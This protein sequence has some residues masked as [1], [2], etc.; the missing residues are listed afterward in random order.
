ME[1]TFTL[2][3]V[4]II[5]GPMA[6]GSVCALAGALVYERFIAG[7]TVKAKPANP[8]MADPKYREIMA[9][10]DVAKVKHAPRKHL[11]AK[12][13]RRVEELLGGKGVS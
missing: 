12:R 11:Y 13:D 1:L 8:L 7:K 4:D 3:P 2:T 5:F 6:F 9:D 10:I